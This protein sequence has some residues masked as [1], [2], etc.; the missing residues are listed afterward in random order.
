MSISFLSRVNA[1]AKPVYHVIDAQNEVVG[2]LAPQ[3]AALLTGKHKPTYLPHSDCGDF[4]IVKNAATARFTGN[5]ERGKLYHWHTGFP[6]GLK[7]L[8]ASQMRERHPEKLISSAVNG[9][10]PKNKLRKAVWMKRLR[11]YSGDVHPHDQ[12]VAAAAGRISAEF[13]AVCKPTSKQVHVERQPV[14]GRE[15]YFWGKEE[16]AEE[17]TAAALPSTDEAAID[18]LW[19][20]QLALTVEAEV[21]HWAEQGDDRIPDSS[22]VLHG[23]KAVKQASGTW[24]YQFEDG[25]ALPSVEEANAIVAQARA[26][27]LGSLPAM[28]EAERK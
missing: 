24:T 14:E 20:A 26:G 15:D 27:T 9:M 12:A 22:L 11:V 18:Q 13:A 2:R 4:V 23:L 10:L 6:G 8:T 19:R 16:P 28:G 3:I 5:K 1:R 17:P 7:T 25:S 21:L